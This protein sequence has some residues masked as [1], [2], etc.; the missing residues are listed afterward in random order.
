M[1]TKTFTVEC[2]HDEWT[3][4]VDGSESA[5][6]GAQ[7]LNRPCDIAI[8]PNVGAIDGGIYLSEDG[9]RSIALPIGSGDKVYAKGRPNYPGNY[10]ARVSGFQVAR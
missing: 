4:L 9:E 8:A 5:E 2:P 1:T 10:P 6:F 7:V 3:L